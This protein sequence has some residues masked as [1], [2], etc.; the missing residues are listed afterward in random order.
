VVERLAPYLGDFNAQVWVK[1]VAQRNLEMEPED[2]TVADLP[3][4]MEGLRP[5]LNTFM[6]RSAADDLLKKVSR[7][8]R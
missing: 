8:V 4:L 2:L 1:V 6:G 7:E 3:P 5:S